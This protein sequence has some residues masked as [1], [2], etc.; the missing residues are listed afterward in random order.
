MFS[1][2]PELVEPGKEVHAR[3]RQDFIATANQ[4]ARE[5]V[6]DIDELTDNIQ[7]VADPAARRAQAWAVE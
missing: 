4:A 2:D 7:Y 1:T 5:G 3:L 6:L